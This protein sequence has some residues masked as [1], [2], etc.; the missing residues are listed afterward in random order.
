MTVV[1]TIE[2]ADDDCRLLWCRRERVRDALF[3][4]EHLNDHYHH[5]LERVPEGAYKPAGLWAPRRP[6]R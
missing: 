4:R 6:V 1:V 5:R 3:C 2:K